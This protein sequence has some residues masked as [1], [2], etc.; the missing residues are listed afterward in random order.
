M[1]QTELSKE[2]E[3]VHCTNAICERNIQKWHDIKC[4]WAN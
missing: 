3:A 2:S 4:Y 1:G